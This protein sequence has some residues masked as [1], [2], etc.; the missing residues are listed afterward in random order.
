M[1]EKINKILNKL[2]ADMK[3]A[4]DNLLDIAEAFYPKYSSDDKI[5]EILD[6]YK[7]YIGD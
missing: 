6:I 7:K 4:L 1:A 2:I 3:F 5:A